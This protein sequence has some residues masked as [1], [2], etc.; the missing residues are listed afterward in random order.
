LAVAAVVS[1]GAWV[2]LAAGW[3]SAAHPRYLEMVEAARTVQRAMQVVRAEKEARGLLQ[4]VDVDPNRTGFVGPEWTPLV[5]TLGHL[6]S[7]RTATN[8]D[9]AAALVR[10]Y[11]RLG[12]RAGDAVAI[13]LSGSFPAANVAA[14]AAAE[15]LGLRPV[16]IASVGASMYGATDLAFTFLDLYGALVAQGVLRTPVRVATLGGTDGSGGGMDPEGVAAARAAAE[17]RGVELVEAEAVPALVDAV[18]TIVAAA[19]GGPIAGVVNV[20]GA[21]VGTGACL[22]LFGVVDGTAMAP[23]RCVGGD[24]GLVTR[25]TEAG[26]VAVHVLNLRFLSL[27]WGLPYDP[28]PL[29]A[30]GN[31]VAVYRR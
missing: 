18:A 22:E 25:Y 24:P 1:L 29:P 17:R 31:N 10:A 14:V 3:S 30:P 16:V 6:P 13:V 15:A 12:L 28:V 4:G 5:T 2:A 26:A 20:G 23:V 11:D 7:K 8:P 19:A 9:L 27:A 21:V